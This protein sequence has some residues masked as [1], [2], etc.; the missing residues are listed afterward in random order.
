MAHLPPGPPLRF[1]QAIR[2]MRDPHTMLRDYAQRYGDVF[3]VRTAR[4]CVMTGRPELIRQILSAPVDQYG[5]NTERG[6]ARVLGENGMFR[7]A[8]RELRRDRRIVV[9]CFQGEIL[10]KLGEMMR[11]A[12]LEAFR[13]LSPGQV[14][15]MRELALDIALDVILRTIFGADTP[16]R[17]GRFREAVQGFTDAYGNHFFLILLILRIEIESLPP[18]RRFAAS[19]ARLEALLQ[20][21]IDRARVE[22][23]DRGDILGR[24]VA[25][26]YEDGSGMSDPALRD[27]LITTLIA[28]HETSVVSLCWAFFWLHRYEAELDRLLAEL[29]PLGPDAAPA[30]Y[31][32]LPFLDAVVKETLRLWPVV[33]DINRVL[34][35]P[36]VLGGYEL[37]PR[38]T[39][40][41]ATAV[42]HYDPDL[43][44]EPERFR[45]ERFL[46][47]RFAAHEYIP[48]GGGERMCPGGQFS[49]FELKVVL[50]TLLTRGRF[51]LLDE[52]PPVVRRMGA[53]SAPNTG[54]RLRYEGPRN[55]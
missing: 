12:T 15:T 44:S 29:E 4:L 41:A 25:A 38:T 13:R 14:L 16:E 35:K 5:V 26:R 39:V 45:P 53:M 8:G 27:N 1:V 23:P 42:V 40:A 47:R 11:E 30:D 3:T 52:G 18:Y 55:G 54:V 49:T 48:F 7:L 50:A 19:R 36:M 34:A 46:E 22:G 51:R 43:Y 33:T 6:P 10:A 9:P 37:P 32:R 21:A 2:Y 28:G 31:A 20:E 17:R 24:L